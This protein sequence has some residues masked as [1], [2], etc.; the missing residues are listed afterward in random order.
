MKQEGADA[1]SVK[2]N[3]TFHYCTVQKRAGT[4]VEGCQT[5]GLG[6]LLQYMRKYEY[7]AESPKQD[8]KRFNSQI[9]RN[10]LPVWVYYLSMFSADWCAYLG[11]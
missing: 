6:H 11:H 9:R 7:N 1:S 2:L 4:E 5:G 3:L 8:S 10:T